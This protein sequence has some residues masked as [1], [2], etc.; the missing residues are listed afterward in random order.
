LRRV[1]EAVRE[2][3]ESEW[4]RTNPEARAR[5]EATVNQLRESISDLE[6]QVEKAR[7]A[8]NDRKLAEAEEALTAR[9][10]WLEQAERALD[11]FR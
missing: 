1:E 4:Q 3:E 5:A 2:A 11:E 7:E 10:A 8:G 6:Q 9:R